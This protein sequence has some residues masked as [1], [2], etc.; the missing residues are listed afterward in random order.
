MPPRKLS[1]FVKEGLRGIFVSVK[2]SL[3]PFFKGEYDLVVEIALHATI[4]L[5]T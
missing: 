4:I 1:P 2:S 5:S 3:A